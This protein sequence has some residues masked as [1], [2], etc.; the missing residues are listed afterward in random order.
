MSCG[1]LSK[2][3]G[4]SESRWGK[5][6]AEG[7]WKPNAREEVASG[8]RGIAARLDVPAETVAACVAHALDGVPAPALGPW[9]EGQCPAPLMGR[10]KGPRLLPRDD[11]PDDY[12]P[13]AARP[14][15]PEQ[16]WRTQ[17]SSILRALQDDDIDERTALD[18][19][20]DIQAPLR[21]YYNK[22]DAHDDVR[23][24]SSPDVA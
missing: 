2:A 12:G 13:R 15:L 14:I 19:I 22:Y 5:L 6:E 7:K 18:A 10:P 8:V 11:R 16:V 17:V 4:W 9:R 1:G 20:A 3:L 21:H 23:D 24:R